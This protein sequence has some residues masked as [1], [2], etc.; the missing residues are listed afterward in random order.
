MQ[1]FNE[2]LEIIERDDK[3]LFK[4][5]AIVFYD[6]ND[7]KTEYQLGK[8]IVERVSPSAVDGLIDGEVDTLLTVNHDKSWS[9]GCK[10][11]ELTLFRDNRGLGFEHPID[12]ED[13]QHQATYNK[14]LKRI[15][16]GCSF[17]ANLKRDVWSKEGDKE[18]RT[19]TQLVKLDDVSICARPAYSGTGVSV[20]DD[21]STDY[22]DSY[23][24]WK[25]EELIKKINQTNK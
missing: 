12:P 25:T 9:L 17:V 20:R 6:P 1:R 10:S 22:L 14:V 13:W 5:Y 21:D 8:N 7:P 18:V 24:R 11:Q 16:K 4:G 23:N 2:T 15:Y 3:K 19:I